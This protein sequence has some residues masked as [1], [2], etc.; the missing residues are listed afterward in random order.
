VQGYIWT[1]AVI[2]LLAC[3][4]KSFDTALIG[5]VN[6]CEDGEVLNLRA[7]AMKWRAMLILIK[8]STWM[9]TTPVMRTRMWMRMAVLIPMIPVPNR[10]Y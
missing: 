9:G 2:G 8:T 1:I 3:S 5:D 6:P 7:I 4:A 10:Q